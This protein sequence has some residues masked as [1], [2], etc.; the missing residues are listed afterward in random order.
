V[1]FEAKRLCIAAEQRGQF[2]VKDFYDL[3]TGRNAAKHSFAERFLFYAANEFSGD[4][5]ID[6]G[7]KQCQAHVAQCSVDVRLAD[8]AVPTEFFE[9]LLKLIAELWKHTHGGT[10]VVAF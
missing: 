9:N 10:R 8:N 5:K 1:V 2:V 7:F 4:L 3:L 6:V